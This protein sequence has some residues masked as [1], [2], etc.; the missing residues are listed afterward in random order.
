MNA[1]TTRALLR[2]RCIDS[3]P[4]GPNVPQVAPSFRAGKRL[5]WRCHGLRGRSGD[6]AAHGLR[7]RSGAR[8]PMT[9]DEPDESLA[10]LGEFAVIDRLVSGRDQPAAVVLGPGEDVMALSDGM[11]Q[12]ALTMGAGIVGGDLVSAPQWVISVTALGELGGR[13]PVLLSGASQGDTVAVVGE[14]GWSAAGLALWDK[15]IEEFPELRRRHLVPRVPYGA[16]RLAADAGA[17]AMTDV[18]DGLLAD[19]AHIADASGVGIN[20]VRDALS[21]DHRALRDAAAAASADAWAWVLGGGEDH[22]LVA[23][24]AGAVPAGWRRIGTVV[25]GPPRVLVDGA[26]WQGNPGWKSF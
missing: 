13:A 7:G 15:G 25:D 22:P 2:S 21:D 6:G 24:F 16:G 11:W 4:Q 19:L 20:V 18:S 1:S 3:S 8:P 12:E 17:T 5:G 9:K 14:L 23:T 10:S 26:G